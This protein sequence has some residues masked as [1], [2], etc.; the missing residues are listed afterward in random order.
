MAVAFFPPHVPPS[1]F[2]IGSLTEPE[3][4]RSARQPAIGLRGS[5]SYLLF[6]K[7]GLHAHVPRVLPEFR[8]FELRF[9]CLH[10]RYFAY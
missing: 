1:C 9:L 8:R 6:W 5:F 4:V 10:S 3:A 2:V 7:A